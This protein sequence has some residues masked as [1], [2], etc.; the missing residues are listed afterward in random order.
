VLANCSR[1][2]IRSVIRFLHAKRFSPLKL[3]AIL[4][5]GCRIET[6]DCQKIMYGLLNLR[7]GI[8]NCRLIGRART[9]MTILNIARVLEILENLRMKI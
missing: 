5:R 9:P 2:E 6:G 7:K 8:R 3:T 1:E 4:Q